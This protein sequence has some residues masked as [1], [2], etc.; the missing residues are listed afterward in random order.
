MIRAALVLTLVALLL[1]ACPSQ[2]DTSRK[3][4]TE[5]ELE[6]RA[7]ETVQQL[8]D[9]DF[10]AIRA[11]F[12]ETMSEGLS[13]DGLR[14]ALANVEAQWG[15]LE[16]KEGNPEIVELGDLTVINVPVQFEKKKAE[17][18]VTFRPDGRIAGFYILKPNV[19]IS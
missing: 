1:G 18:R 17:V 11:D 19:P 4:L 3:S 10:A 6:L 7:V 16:G 13:E 14:E 12:D 5:S 2:V 8:D 9:Q 15:E